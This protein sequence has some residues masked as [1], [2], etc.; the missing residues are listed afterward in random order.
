M[1]SHGETAILLPIRIVGD[2]SFKN[3]IKCREQL[4]AGV[5]HPRM[6][7]TIVTG[8]KA[9][10]APTEMRQKFLKHG[11]SA[12]VTNFGNDSGQSRCTPNRKTLVEVDMTKHNT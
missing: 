10:R 7:H 3:G 12:D 11:K 9:L 1:P 4:V 5:T 2:A 8:L 6:F